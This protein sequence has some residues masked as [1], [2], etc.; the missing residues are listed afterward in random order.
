MPWDSAT[1]AFHGKA[2]VV[3]RRTSFFGNAN[4][5]QKSERNGKLC[6]RIRG[7][8][9]M[10]VMLFLEDEHHKGTALRLSDEADSARVPYCADT[11]QL[12][13]SHARRAAR[14]IDSSVV[15]ARAS[16]R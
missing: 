9:V 7:P 10:D 14:N 3:G 13:H 16:T 8:P 2:I 1:E 4:L 6:W 15:G 11:P 12:A 5:A